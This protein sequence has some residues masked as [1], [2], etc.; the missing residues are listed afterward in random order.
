MS[1]FLALER[2]AQIA[3]IPFLLATPFGCENDIWGQMSLGSL[4]HGDGFPP[5]CSLG[6]TV[7][8]C[9]GQPLLL[10]RILFMGFSPP[11]QLLCSRRLSA[12]LGWAPLA[13]VERFSPATE[14]R[15]CSSH[16]F[17]KDLGNLC[18]NQW[19]FIYGLRIFWIIYL[20]SRM[21]SLRRA[22][23]FRPRALQASAAFPL[24]CLFWFALKC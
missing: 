1:P 13:A 14:E 23:T 2:R 19:K 12:A 18:I 17:L 8:S 5:L 7:T 21:L 24:A 6:W 11:W 9:Q 4:R 10:L 20:M 15:K 3:N 22:F 16:A